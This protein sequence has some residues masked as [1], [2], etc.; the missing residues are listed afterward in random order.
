MIKT[1]GLIHSLLLAP[2]QLS[3]SLF[4]SPVCGRIAV[5][6]TLG[7]LLG[8]FDFLDA[9]IAA[10]THKWL[11]HADDLLRDPENVSLITGFLSCVILSCVTLSAKFVD[12]LPL[13]TSW[14]QMTSLPWLTTSFAR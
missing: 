6:K 1:G 9:S 7:S 11:T 13:V 5:W 8:I 14:L 10:S 12:I 3:S 4:T 2:I